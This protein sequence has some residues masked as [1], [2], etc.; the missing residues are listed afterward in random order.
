MNARATHEGPNDEKASDLD[1]VGIEGALRRC[2]ELAKRI[3][4]ALCKTP[5]QDAMLLAEVHAS[6]D[7]AASL[8]EKK[9]SQSAPDRTAF[10]RPS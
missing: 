2:H 1:R 10:G 7:H 9:D 6:L 3:E 5:L 8:L 4:E